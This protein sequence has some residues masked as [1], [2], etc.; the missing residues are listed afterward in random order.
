MSTRRH[1]HLAIVVLLLIASSAAQTTPQPKVIDLKASDGA[2]LKA[3]YFSA[4]KPGPGVLL[5]HQCDQQRKVWDPLGAALA[6]AG[7]NTLTFD[8]RGYGESEGTPQQ[9]W[10]N[11]ERRRITTELWPG[12]IDV[13][14]QYLLSQ[15]GVDHAKIGAGGASCGV[16]NSAQLARRHPEVKALLLLAGG[17]D[18]DGRLNIQDKKIPVFVGAADDDQ[19][20]QYQPLMQWFLATSNNPASRYQRYATG[21]HGA[22]M[23]PVHPEFPGIIAQ[24]FAAVLNN[25]A[26]KLP[27]TNGEPFA[28]AVAESIRRI[29]E[30]GGAAEVDKKLAEARKQNP[31]AELFPEEIAN[32]IGYEHLQTKDLKGSIE[33]FKLN[34]TA[35]PESPNVYDSLSDAY[36]ADGQKELAL[37]NAKKAIELLATDTK[38]TEDRK[39]AIRESAEQKVKQLGDRGE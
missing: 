21:K 25:Q 28:P 39:K 37:Q 2:V 38:D 10:T 33:I 8:Y 27:K 4:G 14:Y 24:W 12:D 6:S 16:N 5:L 35:Y 3:T 1:S 13:A 22:E 11:E 19:Y 31:K 20:S 23:F 32:L 7:I 9:K 34:V 29:D 26:D 30:S 17:T 15:P 18:R 36:V